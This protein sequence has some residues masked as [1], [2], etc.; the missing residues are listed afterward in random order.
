MYD[1]SHQYSAKVIVNDKTVADEYFHTDGNT[2]I[3]ARKNS[4]YALEL[5]NT[6]AE[7]VMMIPSIDGLS[8]IDGQPAGISSP[9][10]ILNPH[11]K[12]V[13]GGWLKNDKEVA[14]FVFWDKEHSYAEGTGHG[15]LN[16][17]VIGVLVFREMQVAPVS[18][19]TW[20]RWTHSGPEHNYCNVEIGALSTTKGIADQDAGTGH[21]RRQ[22]FRT[23]KTTFEKRD[24]DY[25]DAQIVLYYD[26]S[27]GLE[28]RGITLRYK[29]D[30]AP[31]PF[32]SAPEYIRNRRK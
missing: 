16:T 24:K 5:C 8:V 20:D 29:S 23:V 18:P 10:Y 4:E 9:G 7:R 19:N 1:Y 21:G 28:R 25:P 30:Y 17:G 27:K 14:R 15:S 26:S 12:T 31:D 22:E 3:E 13:I 11:E 32:P 2:Y 6:S